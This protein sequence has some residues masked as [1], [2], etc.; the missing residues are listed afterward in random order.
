M[1]EP[2]LENG[3]QRLMTRTSRATA[4]RLAVLAAAVAALAGCLPIMFD[5]DGNWRGAQPA[6]PAFGSATQPRS[7]IIPTAEDEAAEAAEPAAQ[8]PAEPAADETAEPTA[9]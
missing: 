6:G 7:A 5:R 3:E 8:E 2:S 9:E 4:L 1:A